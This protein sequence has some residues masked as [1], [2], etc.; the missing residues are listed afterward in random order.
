MALMKKIKGKFSRGFTIFEIVIA[1]T[2]I[3]ICTISSISVIEKSRDVSSKAY[4]YYEA[5]SLVEN[6]LEIFKY[7]DN[8]EQFDDAIKYLDQKFTRDGYLYY[9][10]N[11][12]YRVELTV[13]FN[14]FHTDM[15][16]Y[17]AVCYKSTGH[18]LF[19]CNYE[20]L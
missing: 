19:K 2:I 12:L 20:K 10:E 15:S 7:A 6:S 16:T 14:E 4:Y 5:R 3:G 11:N 13:I 8:E 18:Q 17:R 1:M 9:Y